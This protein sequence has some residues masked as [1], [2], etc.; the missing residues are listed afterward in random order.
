[1]PVEIAGET[2][3]TLVE[4]VALFP[5]AARPNE[6]TLRRHIRAGKLIATKVGR[7]SLVSSSAVRQF[8]DGAPAGARAPAVSPETPG[9]PRRRPARKPSRFH[10]ALALARRADREQRKS[11]SASRASKRRQPKH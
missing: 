10:H 9:K 11:R 6:E 2:Y 1:M 8:L 7:G 5:R 3:W 4:L